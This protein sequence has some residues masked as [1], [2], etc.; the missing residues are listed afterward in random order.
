M[1][2][3]L[4]WK[5][6]R[7]LMPLCIAAFAAELLLAGVALNGWRLHRAADVWGIVPLFWGVA[8]LVSLCMGYWQ[9]SHEDTQNTFQ[10]LLHR[11]LRR[12]TILLIKWL[13]GLLIC[14][15]FGPIPILISTAFAEVTFPDQVPS[16]LQMAGGV[17]IG[18][19]ILYGGAF[20]SGLRPARHYT[21]YLPLVAG[22]F[23]F[24][25]FQMF[26]SSLLPRNPLG[27]ACFLLL[28]AP[29]AAC[30]VVVALHVGNT[31]DYS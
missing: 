20:L 2:K 7:E 25:V 26:Y 6:F 1:L 8:V 21:R 30:S 18:I 19:W 29:I 22:F 4:L 14:L 15:V 11:P 31:R 17:C 24:V 16:S 28:A 5:E 10:F 23:L 27:A 12:S 3:A 13:Y 9:N